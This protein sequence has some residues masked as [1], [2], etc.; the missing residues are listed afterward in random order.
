MAK[1]P[2]NF[3]KL[4]LILLFLF[5][6]F[7]PTTIFALDQRCW[8]KDKCTAPEV[9]GALYG[10]NDETITACGGKKNAGGK[11]LGFCKPPYIAQT[12]IDF[13]GRTSFENI[14]VFIKYMFR[15]SVMAAGILSVIM[16]MFAGFE[17]VTSGGNSE[18]IT[19]AKKK[20]SGAIM[21]LLIASLSYALLSTINPYLVNLRLPQAWMINSQGMAPVYCRELKPNTTKVALAYKQSEKLSE[22]DK[23]KNE[24]KADYNQG[25]VATEAKCGDNYFVKDTGAQTC[26]GTLCGQG[27]VCS[28]VLL[29][30]NESKYNCIKGQMIL[31]YSVGSLWQELKSNWPLSESVQYDYLDDDV[32]DFYPVCT[33]GKDGKPKSGDK[34]IVGN[35]WENW[36][37]NGSEIR[38]VVPITGAGSS[39]K[40][41]IVVLG[42]F[43]FSEAHPS[44][45]WNCPDGTNLAGW[46]MKS[47]IGQKMGWYWPNFT[48]G[49][50]I[51]GYDGNSIKYGVWKQSLKPGETATNMVDVGD[52]I[53]YQKITQSQLSI[54][55]IVLDTEVLKDIFTHTGSEPKP[56]QT[57]TNYQTEP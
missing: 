52:Y 45:H 57:G 55:E 36:D 40:S 42:G 37:N 44:T 2:K 26:I 11:E 29:G 32:F 33:Y 54:Q 28:P 49:N 9:G 12:E 24:A 53:P 20:I 50:L 13:G 43:S 46:V 39:F 4:G 48:D 38:Q 35:K 41:Y 22:G 34:L 51:V 3:I 16:I 47:E 56:N 6:F 7:S 10:P 21:G 19:G 17:W 5:W 15:Y 18:K 14:G 31:K 25:V 27:N 8:E 23:Q 1:Q 30:S